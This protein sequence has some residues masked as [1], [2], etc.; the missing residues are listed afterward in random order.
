MIL[1]KGVRGGVEES[2]FGGGGGG[3]GCVRPISRRERALTVF[4]READGQH[5]P[6]F[7]MKDIL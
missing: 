6:R 7:E 1:E 4:I 5:L 2:V 3:W